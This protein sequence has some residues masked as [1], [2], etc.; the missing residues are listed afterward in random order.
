MRG[1]NIVRSHQAFREGLHRATDQR[2]P[3]QRVDR[4]KVYAIAEQVFAESIRR[5]PTGEQVVFDR[6]AQRADET[7]LTEQDLT[8]AFQAAV[9]HVAVSH[10]QYEHT[11]FRADVNA[12]K[13]KS[14]GNILKRLG[15][16]LK[17]SVRSA[18]FYDSSIPGGGAVGG[19]V[20]DIAAITE[21]AIEQQIVKK[22]YDQYM[23]LG[24]PAF[25]RTVERYQ[26]GE[27]TYQELLD[28]PSYVVGIR[29]ITEAL[30]IG[31]TFTLEL[32]DGSDS[33]TFDSSDPDVKT[34]IRRHLAFVLKSEIAQTAEFRQLGVISVPDMPEYVSRVQE[35]PHGAIEKVKHF[36]TSD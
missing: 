14:R 13:D 19:D 26:A 17:L 7:G 24:G 18:S 28:H 32:P 27:F 12:A 33:V 4:G 31:Q 10:E 20:A 30:P 29:K 8:E 34:A 23:E 9:Q 36:F 16:H 22:R 11:Q 21:S 35:Q 15:Q 2:Q 25:R 3:G 5:N 1:V 6:I